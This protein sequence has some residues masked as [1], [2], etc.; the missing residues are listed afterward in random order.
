MIRILVLAVVWSLLSAAAFAVLSG[1][2]ILKRANRLGVFAG[3]SESLSLA[4]LGIME[5]RHGQFAWVMGCAG[6]DFES[7]R[8][9]R[10]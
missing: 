8:S 3:S 2:P 10:G 7:V 5:T 9:R 4:F 6:C 1:P